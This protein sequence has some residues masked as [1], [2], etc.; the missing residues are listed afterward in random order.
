M[1]GHISAHGP[2]DGPPTIGD[3]RWWRGHWT[4]LARDPWRR[5]VA[6]YSATEFEWRRIMTM[7]DLALLLCEDRRVRDTAPDH[8]LIVERIVMDG[9]AIDILTQGTHVPADMLGDPDEL[10]RPSTWHPPIHV[11][12]TEYGDVVLD[13]AL[14][15]VARYRRIGPAQR[16][17]NWWNS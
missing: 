17:K 5:L 2:G 15:T 6:R 1:L 10:V 9:G 14:A 4:R 11:A 7:G 12:G 13:W 8:D 3:G 16:V